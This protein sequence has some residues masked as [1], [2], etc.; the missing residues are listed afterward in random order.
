MRG[1]LV[2][3]LL[4]PLGLAGPAAGHDGC[5]RFGWPLTREIEL[6]SDGYMP[7]VDAS[8]W[9]PREGAFALILAP[10]NSAFYLVTP[11]RGRD[12]GFGGIV[13]LQWIAAGRYQV[14]LTDDAWIDVVQ[15][16]R[17]LPVLASVRRTDCP[18]IRLSL[19]VELDSKPLTLQFGGAKVR[20]LGIVVLRLQ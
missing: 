6:F 7:A 5:G 16:E 19:Q 14:T 8:S 3:L 18:G 17:R 2:A 12:D 11:E 4:M 20:R 13:T 15:D 1:V 9:L 10:V